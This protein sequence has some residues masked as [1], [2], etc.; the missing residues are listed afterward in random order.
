MGISTRSNIQMN[1]HTIFEFIY[2]AENPT[3]EHILTL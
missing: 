2:L 1:I 3:S